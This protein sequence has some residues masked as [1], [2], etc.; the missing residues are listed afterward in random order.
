MS[1]TTTWAAWLRGPWPI[2]L[3]LACHAGLGLSAVSQKSMTFDEGVHLTGG[4]S[5]WAFNDYRLHPENGNWSQRWAALPLWIR[6]YQFPP[7]EGRSWDESDLWEVSDRFLFESGNDVDGMLWL[8][9]AMMAV[10][11][12]SLGLLVYFWSR[13]LFGAYGGVISLTLYAFSPTMLANGFVAT[14]DLLASF[15]FT[16]A[17][18]ALWV[19]LYRVSPLTIGVAGVTLAGALLAKFSGVLV[20]PMACVLLG[21]RLTDRRP[22]R[23]ELGTSRQIQGRWRLLA[24]F[25][26]VA[27][28][29]VALVA[30]I[31]WGS[32]GFRYSAFA[33]ATRH[34]GTRLQVPW[35]KIREPLSSPIDA[36]VQCGRD[37]HLL[38]EAYLYGFAF[39]ISTRVRLG[40]L[41]GQSSLA[42]WASFF[43]TCWA[44]KTPLTLFLLLG[45]AGWG[46]WVY[47]VRRSAT[48]NREAV[49]TRSQLFVL[50][51]LWVL[52]GVYWLFA[53]SSGMNIGHRHILPTYPPLFILAGAVSTW[54]QASPMRSSRRQGAKSQR[55][56]PDGAKVIAPKVL[57]GVRITIGAAL[58]ITMLETAWFWPDYLA[59]FNVLAGG[60]SNAYRW[61]VDSS[62][63]WGQD[64]KALKCWLDEHPDDSR[65]PDRVYLSYF[66][67][68]RPEHYGIDAQMLPG[69]RLRW[70]PH[71]P[72]LLT[73]GVYCISATMLQSVYAKNP[74]RWNA[75]YEKGFRQLR[76][77]IEP[78]VRSGADLAAFERLT[79]HLT[80]EELQDGFQDYEDLRF[81]RLC[82]VLRRREPDD[83]VGYSIL[84]Y[85]LT[86]ADVALALDGRPG[87]LL[88]KPETQTDIPTP[89]SAS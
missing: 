75:A 38:P 6:G 53:I 19:V 78:L 56:Q 27:C 89:K 70:G 64:L 80:P 79:P 77:E 83:R 33:P 69:F 3:L 1:V 47:R 65:D 82:S 72:K 60:P 41:H 50:A 44:L 9:L 32:Y 34:E 67:M 28:C 13:R 61:L 51:P 88:D 76:S 2:I 12:A 57:R 71:V 25:G 74:G 86:D 52:L 17:L 39:T 55:E 11:S 24:A 40:F 15:F 58:L 43:P 21:V 59:Y 14:S 49:D 5:Y 54:F 63:D 4:L 30:L 66:G 45:L 20:L 84:I 10:A 31:I 87:E 23:V 48:R 42:G 26:L 18:G 68:A 73:G 29:E 62:L 16:A 37:Y 46:G 85:R 81:S 35:D 36:T 7:L 8:A 22:L